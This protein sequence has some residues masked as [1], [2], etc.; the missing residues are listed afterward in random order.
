M[1]SKENQLVFLVTDIYFVSG[2]VLMTVG[3]LKHK[4]FTSYVHTRNEKN[5]KDVR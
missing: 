5:K 4:L 2:V 3:L 1:Q